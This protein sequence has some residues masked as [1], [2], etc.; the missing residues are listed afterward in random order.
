[1][2]EIAE[3]K[4]IEQE[5]V[6]TDLGAILRG[7]IKVTLEAV[8]EEEVLALCGTSRGSRDGRRKDVRNGSYLRGLLTQMG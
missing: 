5:E 6:E 3:L 8:L 4:P 2:S 1:M 7:A